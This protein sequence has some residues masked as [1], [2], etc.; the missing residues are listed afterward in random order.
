MEHYALPRTSLP[1]RLYRVQYENSHTQES[2]FGL[3]AGDPTKFDYNSSDFGDTIE[4]HIFGEEIDSP[5]ISCFTS[6]DQAEDWMCRNWRDLGQW[7]QILE[8]R[9]RSLGHGYVYRAAHIFLDMGRD[10]WPTENHD[11]IS[12]E[13]LVL[14]HIKSR[15]IVA[16]R[17]KITVPPAADV[18]TAAEGSQ[19]SA[20]ANLFNSGQ[21]SPR[22]AWLDPTPCSSRAMSI[23]QSSAFESSIFDESEYGTPGSGRYASREPSSPGS[24][25]RLTA[26]GRVNMISSPSVRS[27]RASTASSWGGSSLY[28]SQR[29]SISELSDTFST[30]TVGGASP[31]IQSSPFWESEVYSDEEGPRR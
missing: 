22:E 17:A 13:I 28:S 15:A 3:T 19:T 8:I 16:R 12:G 1:R 31:S 7:A 21:S 24:L 27:S 4:A 2:E 14:H 29:T 5:L 26:P 6:K 20:Q 10:P 30:T 18:E 25:P 11:D 23:A 9:T